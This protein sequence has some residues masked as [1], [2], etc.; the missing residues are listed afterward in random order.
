[1]SKFNI[2]LIGMLTGSLFGVLFAPKK[3]SST[4]KSISKPAKASI[5]EVRKYIRENSP[6]KLSK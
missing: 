4:R 3:G 5:E 1:M 6:S 2:F